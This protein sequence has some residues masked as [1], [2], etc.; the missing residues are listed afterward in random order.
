MSCLSIQVYL[1]LTDTGELIAVKQMEVNLVSE[2][3]LE[4]EYSKIYR[5]VEILKHLK[6]KNIVQ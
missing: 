4:A 1:G 5:E 6:H 3:E 2:Q